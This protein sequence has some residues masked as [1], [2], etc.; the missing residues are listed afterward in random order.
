VFIVAVLTAAKTVLKTSQW[1]VVFEGGIHCDNL[2]ANTE[3]TSMKTIAWVKNLPGFTAMPRTTKHKEPRFIEIYLQTIS[4][5]KEGLHNTGTCLWK[6]P[7]KSVP[8][9]TVFCTILINIWLRQSPSP[10]KKVPALQAGV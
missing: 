1:S 2:P 6:T 4:T 8:K 3:K 9:V 5:V 10:A 7:A